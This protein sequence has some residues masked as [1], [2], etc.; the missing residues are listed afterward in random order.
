VDGDHSNRMGPY[1]PKARFDWTA[2]EASPSD[3][4]P[5][6]SPEP[7]VFLLFVLGELGA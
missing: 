1:D 5:R 2:A 6:G 7:A 4:G 3:A